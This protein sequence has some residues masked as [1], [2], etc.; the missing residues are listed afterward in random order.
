MQNH[1]LVTIKRIIYERLKILALEEKSN[2][3]AS[4][5]VNLDQQSVGRLSRMD[6]LQQQAMAK[7]MNARRKNEKRVLEEALYRIVQDDY[8]ECIDCGEAIEFNRLKLKP[9]VL[10]C[11]D[12]MKL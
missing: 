6:A 9:S 1:E 10:K 12:C 4:N 3:D 11:L 5:T 2:I 8:G 7:A